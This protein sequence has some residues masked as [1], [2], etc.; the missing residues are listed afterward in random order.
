LDT[1]VTPRGHAARLLFGA[2]VLDLDRAE[3]RRDGALLSLRP[4]A[5]ALLSYLAR[6]PQRV[7]AKD[8][9]LGAVWP[10]VVVTDDSVSQCVSELRAAL[11]DRDASLIKTVSRRGY[12]LDAAVRTEAAPTAGPVSADAAPPSQVSTPTASPA[13]EV[14]R[15]GR[16][17]PRVAA[18]VASLVVVAA[19]AGWALY[20]PLAPVRIDA[21][22]AER[23][24][25]AVMPFADLSDPP[26][27]HVA[28]AVDI[29]LTTDLGRLADTRVM[30]RASAAALGTSANVDIK[31]VGRELDVR[32]VVTGSVKRDG[33]RLH[34]TV[35]LARADTGALLWTERFDYVSAADWLTQRDVSGR[36]ANLLDARLGD[37]AREE[38]RRAP[39][40]DKALDHW[41]RGSYILSRMKTKAELL[42]A[43]SEFEAAL[44]AQ[45]DSSR[46]LSGL[47][48]THV[49][50]SLYH[51]AEDRNATLETAERL[52]RRALEIDPQDQ[53]AMMMLSNALNF[54]GRLEEAM[55]VTRRQLV[56]NPNDADSNRDL[57][58]VLYF[59]GR[60][61]ETLRQLEIPLKLNPLDPTNVWKIHSIAANSLI[62]LRRYDE[63]IEHARR[64]GDSPHGGHLHLAAAEALRGNLVAARQHAAEALKRQPNFTIN[65]QR[66]SRGSTEPAFVA[67][68][69]HYFEGLRQAGLP[70]G[71]VASR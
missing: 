20:R 45:P 31:R 14:P 23:R 66:A 65:R 46:A 44:A 67:G 39:P 10:D 54:N 26:A 58:A 2:F 12:L 50:E 59:S 1:T 40:N 53:R 4:K 61:E 5:F 15:A 70:E 32:H 11:G 29:D 62:A 47:A 33:Q 27:P 49:C 28:Q 9:L 17:R 35:Q 18:A 3:L 60:W 7:L 68:I 41:M 8:E 42:Q 71:V 64:A 24:S 51:W 21:A 55:V 48:A 34:I 69:E 30:A 37:A 38:A 63:A 52:A 56:A 22:V 25:L 57:A 13:A 19:V 43:R 16:R 6:H 36:I